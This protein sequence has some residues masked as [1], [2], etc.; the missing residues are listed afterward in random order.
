MSKQ[1][2]IIGCNGQD[3]S[4]LTSHLIKRSYVV[5][6]VGRKD[7]DIL[8]A[9]KVTDLV[10]HLNPAEIYYLAAHHHS[11][12]NLPRSN[13]DL[14]TQSMNVHFHGVVNFLDAI[15]L[16]NSSSR[17]F[18]AS[19]SHIFGAEEAA[20][21]TE[22]TAWAPQSEY[23]ISKAAG[24]Q[25]CALYRRNHNVFASVG[26]L[27]NHESNFR[28]NYFLSKKIVSAAAS[29]GKTGN[30]TLELGNLD[31]EVDWGYAPD[32]V[33][34]MHRILQLDKADDFI[35][36]T[37]KLH[38]VRDFVEIA[39]RTVGLNYADHV[40]S[41]RN[42]VLRSNGRRVGNPQKLKVATGWEP[43]LDFTQMVRKLVELEQDILA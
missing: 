3:G 43:T 28:K 8:D 24:M 4:L 42:T 31:A 20:M 25:A 5:T 7:I 41:L 39:F 1:A 23:A 18:Y 26:I 16:A 13:A 2:L 22:E 29:I 19:S 12:E 15:V 40:I 36:A 27:F 33:D 35:I 34:A 37:G 9:S 17:L 38:T 6:G 11:S 30:G 21:Q 32:Y 10:R 14:F